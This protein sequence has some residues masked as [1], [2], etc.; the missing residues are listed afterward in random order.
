MKHQKCL[1]IARIIFVFVIALTVCFALYNLEEIYE[2]LIDDAVNTSK[3][4][5]ISLSIA[6]TLKKISDKSSKL[7]NYGTKMAHEIEEKNEKVHLIT[8]E[9]EI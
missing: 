6:I 2:S 4:M 1:R 5:G 3:W 7:I 9:S 8:S